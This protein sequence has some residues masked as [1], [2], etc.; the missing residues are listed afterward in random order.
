MHVEH[1]ST[2]MPLLMPD[3]YIR[4]LRPKCSLKK[5]VHTDVKG[6]CTNIFIS[7]GKASVDL[8][9]KNIHSNGG[10]CIVIAFFDFLNLQSL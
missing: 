9:F 10:V 2:S 3:W 8:G 7:F 4:S 6:R 5:R 1:K